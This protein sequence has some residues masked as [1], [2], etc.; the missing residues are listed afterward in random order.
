MSREEKNTAGYIV[1][2]ISEFATHFKMLPN[3]AYLYLKRY[4]G[5]EHI[6]ENY[7]ILHTLSFRDAVEAMVDVCNN[8]GGWLK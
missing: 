2:L 1:A 8:N 7:S 4:K 6:R 5:L 3:E